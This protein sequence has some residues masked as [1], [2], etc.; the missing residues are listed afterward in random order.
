[1]IA[2]KIRMMLSH[3]FYFIGDTVSRLLYI[4]CLSGI[5]YPIYTK[6]MIWSSDLDEDG[7]I[8][9]YPNKDKS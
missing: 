6:C 3:V 4:D 9:D 5:F 8:W 2:K 1:M 7:E